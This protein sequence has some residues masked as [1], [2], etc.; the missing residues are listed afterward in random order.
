M[1][2]FVENRIGKI[3]QLVPEVNTENKKS[4]GKEKRS[5]VNNTFLFS[6]REGTCGENSALPTAGTMGLI[7]DLGTRIPHGTTQQ[8]AN[9]NK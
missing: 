7:P 4:T 1:S 2:T 9:N 3:E 6:N 8:K 5:W